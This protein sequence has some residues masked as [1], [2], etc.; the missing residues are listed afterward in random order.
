MRTGCTQRQRTRSFYYN[1]Y[2]KIGTARILPFLHYFPA[3]PTAL[4]PPDSPVLCRR[5]QEAVVRRLLV[6]TSRPVVTYDHSLWPRTRRHYHHRRSDA[7]VPY[8]VPYLIFRTHNVGLVFGTR[9]GHDGLHEIEIEGLA[10]A[11]H[12]G[13]SKTCQGSAVSSQQ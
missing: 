8:L 4:P 9:G 2:K 5:L 13:H 6:A 12:F 1:S 11:L 7:F 10:N 3:V